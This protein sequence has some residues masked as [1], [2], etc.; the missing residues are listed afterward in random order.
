MLTLGKCLALGL[1]GNWQTL[2]SFGR[3]VKCLVF[4]AFSIEFCKSLRGLLC[5]FS[6]TREVLSLKVKDR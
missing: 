2:L 3:D 4:F 6:L 1:L 5:L